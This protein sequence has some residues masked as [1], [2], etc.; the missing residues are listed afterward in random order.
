M[1]NIA[2]VPQCSNALLRKVQ[3]LRLPI[4]YGKNIKIK[5]K[6]EGKGKGK[7][8]GKGKAEGKFDS[9]HTMK[10]YGTIKYSFTYH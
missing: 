5:V 2:L 3:H 1:V 7:T 4:F 6:G 9:L 8:K 10:A